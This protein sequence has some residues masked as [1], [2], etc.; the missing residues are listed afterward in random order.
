M[1][2][3][4]RVETSQ[5]GSHI[6]AWS[7][8]FLPAALAV[9]SILVLWGKSRGHVEEIE[10]G[11]LYSQTLVTAFEGVAVGLRDALPLAALI[12]AALAS[13]SLAG[14]QSRG[15]LRNLLMCPVG[16]SNL[17]LGKGMGVLAAAGMCYGLM[18][19]ASI[20]ASAVVFDFTD[21]VEQL[22]IKGAD[23]FV[24]TEA[25]ALWP[26]FLKMLPALILPLLAYTALG[27]LAG[28]LVQRGVTALALAVGLV[29]FL[30]LFRVV[31]RTF[32]FEPALCSAHLPSPLGDT[33]WTAHLIRLIRA[34]NDPPGGTLGLGLIVPLIWLTA[35]IVLATLLLS[36]RSVP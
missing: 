2:R 27:F 5:I 16:R 13:Q 6:T 31:G 24:I 25:A 15:T 23:P 21:V 12:C 29:V 1:L 18:L 33:S 32:G 9:L 22:E 3:A 7:P 26:P 14:E 8:L 11:Q 34:P 20:G 28:A 35:S 17:C 10:T 36:R 19:V 4:F 30:D